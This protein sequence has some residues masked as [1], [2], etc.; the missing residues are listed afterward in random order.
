[1]NWTWAQ[2]PGL[3]FSSL[4]NFQSL[5]RHWSVLLNFITLQID[6]E[7]RKER[8]EGERGWGDSVRGRWLIEGR[9]FFEEI[10]DA[11]SANHVL[12]CSVSY[13]HNVHW[14]VMRETSRQDTEF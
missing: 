10:R 14:S 2:I 1:M 13:K 3:K 12:H 7:G 5:N 4:I 9:L 11:G 6:R 8:E